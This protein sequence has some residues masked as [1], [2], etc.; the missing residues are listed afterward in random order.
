M[1]TTFTFETLHTPFGTLYLLDCGTLTDAEYDRIK[2]IIEYL[3]GHWSEKL[4]RFV[5]RND[6][7]AILPDLIKKGISISDQYKY[8]ERTQF[9]PTPVSV[10]RRTVE[11]CD[12]QPGMKVLE[13]SAGQGRL[14]DQI[15]VS[16]EIVCV[17][18]MPENSSVLRRKGYNTHELFFEDFAQNCG[19]FDRIVMNPPFSLQRDALHVMLAYSL[20]RTGGVLTAIVSENSLYYDTEISDLFRCFLCEVDAEIES[21]PFSAFE[22]SGTMIDTVIIRIVKH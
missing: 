8:Q 17:E 14:V 15:A 21:V 11:L 12:I 20:L 9:Y 19:M 16:C 18:P 1:R 4:H 3:K 22:E 13:P 7:S 5:F 2:P 6:V 10:A